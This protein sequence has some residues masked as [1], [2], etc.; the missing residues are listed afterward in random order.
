MYFH[1]RNSFLSKRRPQL[2]AVSKILAFEKAPGRLI[3][4]LR[5]FPHENFINKEIQFHR[6]FTL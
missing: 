3:E 1:V 6:S 5:Y 4:G 2:S